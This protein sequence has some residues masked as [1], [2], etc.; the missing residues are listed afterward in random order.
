MPGKTTSEGEQSAGSNASG[1]AYQDRAGMNNLIISGLA[2]RANRVRYL[3]R[4]EFMHIMRNRQNFRLLL[5]APILQLLVFGYACRLDVDKVTTVVADLDRSIMSRQIV[6]AFSRSGYFEIV[7]QVGSYDDVDKFLLSGRAS[8]AILIPP[9]LERRVQ[10]NLTAQVAILIDGVDTTTAGTVSGYAQSILQRFSV[11]I[12][13]ERTKRMQGMLFASTTP[14]LIVPK[15]TEASRSWF[16]L[17]LKSKDFFVPGTVVL[18][19]LAM[20]VILTSSVVVREKE[21]GTLEQ[22]MVA[23]IS[24]LELILGKTIPCFVIE[25]ITFAVIVPLAFLI[26]AIP[27]RGSLWF[28]FFTSLLFLITA[29]GVGVTISAFCRTQQQAILSSFM[30]IQPA[31][32]LSGFAFPIENM[33]TVIQYITYINPLRYFMTIVRGVFLKGTGWEVLWPQVIPLLIMGIVSIAFAASL[34]QK[35]MK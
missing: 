32:L 27:F 24:R 26:Y 25:V 2:E 18:I 10:G 19:L 30:F 1:T 12:I 7:E 5:V 21:I 6:D 22:L 31:V 4:K 34:F 23:P 29:S 33:P 3:V 11:D 35:R 8:L 16:N 20:S 15:V 14:R 17:N 9:D 28:F 13:N